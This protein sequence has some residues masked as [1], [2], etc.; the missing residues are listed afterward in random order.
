MSITTNY[1]RKDWSNLLL[2]MLAKI[3]LP[4]C[5][6]MIIFFIFVSPMFELFPEVTS[7]LVDDNFVVELRDTLFGKGYNINA[8]LVY[9]ILTISGG[10]LLPIIF[11]FFVMIKLLDLRAWVTHKIKLKDLD[12][13]WNGILFRETKLG[14]KFN[15][16]TTKL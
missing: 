2:V 15:K 14:K 4:F 1:K 10:I 6:T 5:G 8:I 7:I 13:F 12:F 11:L 9:W 3:A 16:K